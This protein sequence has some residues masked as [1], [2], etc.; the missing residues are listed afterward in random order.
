MSY[1][2]HVSE[3]KASLGALAVDMAGPDCSQRI[4]QLSMKCLKRLSQY[5]LQAQQ[6]GVELSLVAELQPQLAAEQLARRFRHSL[7]KW[8]VTCANDEERAIRH[9]LARPL[10][11]LAG[12]VNEMLNHRCVHWNNYPI[13]ELPDALYMLRGLRALY[14]RNTAIIKISRKIAKLQ[15]LEILD[16]VN[17]K[18]ITLPKQLLGLPKLTQVCVDDTELAHDPAQQSSA[19][20]RCLNTSGKLRFRQYAV[21]N[22]PEAPHEI[23]ANFGILPRVESLRLSVSRQD[24]QQWPTGT[25]GLI[26]DCIERYHDSSVYLE[27]DDVQSTTQGEVSTSLWTELGKYLFSTERLAENQIYAIR[28]NQD[29]DRA[30]GNGL[31]PVLRLG[32]LFPG[33]S[34]ALQQL[35]QMLAWGANRAVPFP[36]VLS[37]KLFAAL[38][39]R[40][41]G[42]DAFQTLTHLHPDYRLL[43]D[44]TP[45]DERQLELVQTEATTYLEATCA[46]VLAQR[47]L[48]R[49]AVVEQD[50][51]QLD[52]LD[53]ILYGMQVGDPKGMQMWQQGNRVEQFTYNSNS[54]LAPMV[55]EQE[56][57]PAPDSALEE[58]APPEI[59][60]SRA[61]TQQDKMTDLQEQATSCNAATFSLYAD[62]FHKHFLGS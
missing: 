5:L 25:L 62:L 58:A 37:P 32:P 45:V 13:A 56:I 28:D 17:T 52:M 42:E 40:L 21:K 49:S 12:D 11:G 7:H 6:S 16:L 44:D 51:L 61:Y 3:S 20:V 41:I 1:I 8:V 23:L 59:G 18:I 30:C 43:R 24:M 47:S 29:D 46:N 27:L 39:S 35:G 54:S 2:D 22:E 60:S 4:K 53:L 15:N 55:P 57:V 9:T 48:I 26:A 38:Y 36:S 50:W 19:V 10:W 33:D 14:L 31:I 34:T